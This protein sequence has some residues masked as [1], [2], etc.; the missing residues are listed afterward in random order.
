MAPLKAP[1][2][3]S[4]LGTVLVILVV[5]AVLGGG[6][7]WYFFYGPGATGKDGDS[8]GK[9]VEPG[10]GR[11]GDQPGVKPGLPEEPEAKDAG[12]EPDAGTGEIAVPA[13]EEPAAP[14]VVD[15]GLAIA[16]VP[17]AGAPVDKGPAIKPPRP[18]RPPVVVKD[19]TPKR[20]PELAAQ[21]TKKGNELFK[22]GEYKEA[23]KEYQ[24][25]LAADPRTALAH[26]GL[27]VCYAKM[28]QPQNACR[29][30]KAYMKMLPEDS[31]EIPALEQI[32][33]DCK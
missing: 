11:P 12:V 13:P 32:L 18:P 17:D 26:R 7:Y 3:S 21:L 15:A 16:E 27:G 24:K 25:A 28:S 33:K 31:K 10:G 4:S 1:R 14:T 20:Q 19:T 29:E 8:I 30:Y 6:A 22:K 5:L 2:R 23:I 9:V